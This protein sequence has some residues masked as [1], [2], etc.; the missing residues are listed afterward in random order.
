[1][2]LSGS[3]PVRNLAD[4]GNFPALQIFIQK[5]WP[6]GFSSG[7]FL[8]FSTF[9]RKNFGFWK[10]Q[11]KK[12]WPKKFHGKKIRLYELSFQNFLAGKNFGPHGHDAIGRIIF[13]MDSNPPS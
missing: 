12:I 13:R 7:I 5:I 4:P 1:M 9:D 6:Y 10:F 8:D 3:F 2:I 11:T